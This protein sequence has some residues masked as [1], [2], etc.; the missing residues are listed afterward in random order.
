[1][2]IA[3]W[4]RHEAPF[5]HISEGDTSLFFSLTRRSADTQKPS[6]ALS[7]RGDNA[8]QPICIFEESI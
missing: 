3:L 4:A 2:G 7:T 1:M 5:R 6:S 8:N